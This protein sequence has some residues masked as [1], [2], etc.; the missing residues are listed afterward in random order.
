MPPSPSSATRL[1]AV[2]SVYVP[3]VPDPPAAACDNCARDDDAANLSAVRR[4]YLE[5]D[6]W[7]APQ[8]ART[9]DEVERWC[10]ACRT[11]YPH[12]QAN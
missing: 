7:D 12:E 11:M 2:H 5:L 10:A 6:E 1:P 9:V 4:V 8:R 3:F